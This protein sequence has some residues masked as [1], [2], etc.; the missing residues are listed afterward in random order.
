MNC[1]RKTFAILQSRSNT[2]ASRRLD[3]Y[4]EAFVLRSSPYA[5]P[6]DCSLGCFICHFRGHDAGEAYALILDYLRAQ[7]DSSLA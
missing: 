1:A 6:Y 2:T 7:N 5:V 4:D 3:C